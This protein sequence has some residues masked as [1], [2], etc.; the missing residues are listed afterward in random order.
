MDKKAN[1]AVLLTCFN[2]KQNTLKCLQQLFNLKQ[3]IDV[4]LVDDGSTDGTGEAILEKFPQVNLIQG[5][6]NLFWNRG[7]HLAWENAAKNDYYYYYLWLNDDVVLYPD[8][9]EELLECAQL[10]GNKSIISGIIESA[11]DQSIIY[12]GT[13]EEKQLICPNGKL[14]P[15]TNMNGNVVLISRQV[16]RILGNLDP[17]YHHDLG[18]VDYGNRAHKEGIGVFTTRVVVASGEKNDFCRVRLN[19][20][21]LSKRIK[22]LYSPLGSHPRINFY[23]RRKH[24]GFIN[25]SIYY[26]LLH[27]INVIPDSVNRKIFGNRYE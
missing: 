17:M 25:A 19:K 23:F 8:C 10:T 14:N 1:L 3:D 2:R 20:A 7:M 9:F 6:G 13:N 4:Y 15:I 11:D 26:C 12:G 24:I 18:D 22:R 21:T 16:Y 27:F 5:S